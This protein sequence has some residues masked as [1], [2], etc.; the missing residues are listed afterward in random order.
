VLAADGHT[1]EESAIR[2]WLRK[3]RL[4]PMTGL[5]LTSLNLV[6]NVNLMQVRMV[7]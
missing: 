3:S 4:S 1:Y 7:M 6:P 5:P 2:D